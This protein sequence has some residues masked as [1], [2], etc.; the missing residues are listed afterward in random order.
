MNLNKLNEC[1]VQGQFLQ[2]IVCHALRNYTFYPGRAEKTDMV[3][4]IVRKY[5]FLKDQSKMGIAHGTS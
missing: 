5:P 2:V 4:A 3:G 1:Y